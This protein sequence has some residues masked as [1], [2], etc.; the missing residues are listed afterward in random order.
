M[1]QEDFG[2]PLTQHLA[3]LSCTQWALSQNNAEWIDYHPPEPEPEE[4]VCL[5]IFL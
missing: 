4:E 5:K 1:L 2:S 3:V